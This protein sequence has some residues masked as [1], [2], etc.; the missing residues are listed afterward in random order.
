MKL[1]GL[2]I[3]LATLL[4]ACVTPVNNEPEP[5]SPGESFARGLAAFQQW[6]IGRSAASLY[7]A[8]NY[9]NQASGEYADNVHW[10]NYYYRTLYTLSALDWHFWHVRLQQHHSQLNKLVKSDLLPPAFLDYRLQEDSSDDQRKQQLLFRALQQEPKSHPVWYHLS[11]FYQRQSQ[12]ELAL[13]AALAAEKHSV[14]VANVYFQVGSLYHQLAGAKDCSYEYPQLDRQAVKYL[15]KSAG[16][17]PENPDFQDSLATIYNHIGLF[18]L[19][20]QVAKKAYDL[21]KSDL[22]VSGLGDAHYGMGHY[23]EAGKLFNELATSYQ[24]EWAYENLVATAMVESRWADAFGHADSMA[25]AYPD[26]VYF[27]VMKLWLRQLSNTPGSE[28]APVAKEQWSNLMLTYVA[29]FTAQEPDRLINAAGNVCQSTEA[30]FYTAMRWWFAGE[31][32]RAKA[33]LETVLAL[34]NYSYLEYRWARA[35]L[36]SDMFPG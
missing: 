3:L 20:L 27:Y 1:P 24:S 21:Q 8:E 28:I 29:D 30:H 17:Q 36:L 7:L 26:D 10:Q 2:L 9:L 11:L 13:Y 25:A 22:T 35:M 4:T 31:P 14:D 33:H 12:L 23:V 5:I 6:E 32:A 15:A 19:A 16:L 34:K 18:P